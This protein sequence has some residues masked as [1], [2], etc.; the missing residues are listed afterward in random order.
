M[1]PINFFRNLLDENQEPGQIWIYFA[2]FFIRQ[3]QFELA[4][5]IFEESLDA[6]YSEN[7]IKSSKDFGLVFNSYLKFE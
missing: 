2:E 3:G 7:S 4:R 5:D 1:N 6:Q